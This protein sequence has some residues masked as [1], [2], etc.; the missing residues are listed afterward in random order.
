MLSTESPRRSSIPFI[1]PEV[2]VG[3]RAFLRSLHSS[4]DVYRSEFLITNHNGVRRKIVEGLHQNGF[5][6]IWI[7]HSYP[8]LTYRV[9][10]PGLAVLPCHLHVPVHVVCLVNH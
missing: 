8:G 1:F 5:D 6:K 9:A 3:L 4:R 7:A 10:A 2:K